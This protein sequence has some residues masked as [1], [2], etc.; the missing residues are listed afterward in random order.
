MC[1][2]PAS[3]SLVDGIIKCKNHKSLC[4]CLMCVC[5]RK[6]HRMCTCLHVCAWLACIIGVKSISPDATWKMVSKL[7]HIYLKTDPAALH[8]MLLILLMAFLSSRMCLGDETDPR[9]MHL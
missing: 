2:N 4:S 6:K 7:Q 3:A 9:Q 1:V 8:G 5:V